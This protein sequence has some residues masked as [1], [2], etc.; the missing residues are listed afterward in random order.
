MGWDVPETQAALLACCTAESLEECAGEP[1]R[2][3]RGC[4]QALC[5]KGLGVSVFRV[6][7]VIKNEARFANCRRACGE[8]HYQFMKRVSWNK[9]ASPWYT[10]GG[11]WK[12]SCL[13]LTETQ[14][15]GN[16]ALKT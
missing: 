11:T 6:S 8:W 14:A 1:R 16:T 9:Y 4:S 15:A 12:T 7:Q 5:R 10:A 2:A 13:E 3:L